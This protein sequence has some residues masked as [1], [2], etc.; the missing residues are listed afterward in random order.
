[1]VGVYLTVTAF[2]MHKSTV[3]VDDVDGCGATV[4]GGPGATR[5]CN[6]LRS[7][8]RNLLPSKIL[9]AARPDTTNSGGSEERGTTPC[10]RS[11]RGPGAFPRF[12]GGF[13]G[14]SSS[15]GACGPSTAV[16]ALCAQISSLQP[17][18]MRGAEPPTPIAPIN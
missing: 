15:S 7:F 12:T 14:K 16:N 18:A 2:L 6:L 3:S 1:D 17:C 11:K 4:L 10:G 13:G 9:A 8:A 5:P